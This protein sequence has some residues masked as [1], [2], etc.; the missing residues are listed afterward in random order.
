[1]DLGEAKRLRVVP[2]AGVQGA[3]LPLDVWGQSPQKL[4]Y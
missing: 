4:E 1:M 2:P 3:E